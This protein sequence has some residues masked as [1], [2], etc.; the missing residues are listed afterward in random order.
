MAAPLF[1]S[2]ADLMTACPLASTDLNISRSPTL[3]E[4]ACPTNAFNY[5]ASEASQSSLSDVLH[6]P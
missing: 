2:V 5:P 4:S 1:I 3:L 6:R